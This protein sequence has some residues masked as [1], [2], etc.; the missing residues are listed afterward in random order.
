MCVLQV[1]NTQEI[2][3]K[4]P[5]SPLE[6]SRKATKAARQRARKAEKSLALTLESV[7]RFLSGMVGLGRHVEEREMCDIYFLLEKQ[8]R[9]LRV[10]G[11]IWVERQ[12]F[13][14]AV[15]AGRTKNKL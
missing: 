15:H 6:K 14:D 10:P 7:R 1:S 12:A 9:R 13:V 3:L 11:G 2:Q 5:M 4:E 8:N